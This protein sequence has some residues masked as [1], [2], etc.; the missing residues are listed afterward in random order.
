M[1]AY[2]L[3]RDGFGVIRLTDGAAVPPD[4]ANADWRQYQAWLAAGNAPDPAET[5]QEIADRQVREAALSAR[6]TDRHALIQLVQDLTASI[7]AHTNTPDVSGTA[8]ERL[9]RLEARTLLTEQRITRLERIAR[10]Y[11]KG[12]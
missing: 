8:V 9:T 5:A 10:H 7:Q 11:L 2:R 4:T 3:S 6:E 1:S 12:L